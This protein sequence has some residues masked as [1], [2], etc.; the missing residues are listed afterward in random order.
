MIVPAKS[1]PSCGFLSKINIAKHLT[2]VR[3][4]IETSEVVRV[5]A[6]QSHRSGVISEFGV[7]VLSITDLLPTINK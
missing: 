5:F 1:C 3:Q 6:D 2:G 7:T 4:V